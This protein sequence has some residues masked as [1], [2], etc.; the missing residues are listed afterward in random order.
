MKKFATYNSFFTHCPTLLSQSDN[1]FEQQA[2]SDLDVNSENLNNEN[3][4]ASANVADDNIVLPEGSDVKEDD[5]PGADQQ[6]L[7]RN[8]KKIL[9]C[10]RDH[11]EIIKKF[12]I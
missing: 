6:Q 2:P 12:G 1:S 7:S 9:Q 8:A 4:N 3:Y 5:F 11:D 10:M